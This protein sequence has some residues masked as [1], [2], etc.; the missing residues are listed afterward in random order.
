MQLPSMFQGIPYE[1]LLQGA[2]AGAIAT[3]IIG[4]NWGGWTLESTATKSSNKMS[5]DAVTAVL[6]PICVENFKNSPDAA[7]NLV[8]FQSESSYNQRG[9]IEDGG[10]AVFP[11]SP[12]TNRDVARACATII[13]ELS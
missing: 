10:W 1:R 11:G 4:F 2:V 7:G 12:D 5:N 3:M 13:S 6:T 8:K 9:F